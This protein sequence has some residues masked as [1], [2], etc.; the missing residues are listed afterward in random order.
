MAASRSSQAFCHVA[1]DRSFCQPGDWDSDAGAQGRLQ[2]GWQD[3]AEEDDG[4]I[5]FGHGEGFGN[6]GRSD[7]GC[8]SVRKGAGDWHHTESVGVGLKDNDGSQGRYGL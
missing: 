7:G 2:L 6:F 8:T 5:Y 4:Q 3:G 1:D